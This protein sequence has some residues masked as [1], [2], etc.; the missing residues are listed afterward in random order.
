MV[1]APGAG[2]AGY[3]PPQVLTI[4]MG[5][6]LVYIIMYIFYFMFFFQGNVLSVKCNDSII[7][8]T[9]KQTKTSTILGSK[10]VSL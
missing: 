9:N 3:G 10:N 7:I 2:L 6:R 5:I 1:P 4:A 8:K